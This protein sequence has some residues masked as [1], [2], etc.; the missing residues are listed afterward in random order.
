M[1]RLTCL[2]LL[3]LVTE[4]FAK[5][6]QLTVFWGYSMSVGSYGKEIGTNPHVTRRDGFDVGENAGFAANGLSFA[7]ELTLPTGV[8]GLAWVS[9]LSLVTNRSNDATLAQTFQNLLGTEEVEFK[10]G[11]WMLAPIMTGFEFRIPVMKQIELYGLLQGGVSLIHAAE[12]NAL[13][14]GTSVDRRK[15]D[16]G[17]QFGYTIGGG[18]VIKHRIDLAMRFMDFGKPKF[19]G[20]RELS[21]DYFNNA[22]D[23][24]GDDVILGKAIP[25]SFMLISVGYRF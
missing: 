14:A 6:G 10:Y 4:S 2:F 15:Y 12:R 9:G 24:I 5:D 25:V 20:I 18:I 16:L 13:V 1:K 3:L 22:F 23:I 19:D 21:D 17:K 11:N 7:I 8:N